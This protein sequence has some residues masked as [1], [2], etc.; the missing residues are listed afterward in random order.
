VFYAACQALLY[1]L[2]YRLGQLMTGLPP[3]EAE[4]ALKAAPNEQPVG[5]HA[6]AVQ[7]LFKEAIPTVLHHR[8][9]AFL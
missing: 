2:C 3:N 7:Q 8:C 6:D 1:V 9:P 5:P 4:A